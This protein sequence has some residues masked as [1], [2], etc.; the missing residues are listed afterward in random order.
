VAA[1]MSERS[2]TQMA[3]EGGGLVSIALDVQT[4]FRLELRRMARGTGGWPET[5][6]Y[7]VSIEAS[8]CAGTGISAEDRA[9][10]LRAAGA[11]GAVPGDLVTPGHVMPL[12]VPEHLN[13]RSALPAFGR[14]IVA[15]H[16]GYT[17]A[18]WCDVLGQDGDVAGIE[19]SMALAMRLSAP[20]I[21]VENG[22]LTSG[23]A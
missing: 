20:V 8:E 13:T 23:A 11:P 7:L 18:A 15:Q 6:E 5:E 14:A 10:T 9:L 4:A 3:I 1:L 19:E 21:T 2:V 17:V 22:A 16:T 12:L